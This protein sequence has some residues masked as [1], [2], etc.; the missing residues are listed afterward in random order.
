VLVPLDTRPLRDREVDALSVALIE[1]AIWFAEQIGGEVHVL[2]AWLPYGDGPMRQA[3]VPA[4]EI[5]EYH[6]VAGKE[7]LDELEKVIA[8]FRDR[9]ARTGVHVKIG[10]PRK[11]ISAF[12]VEN[13]V[14]LIVIGTVARSGIR[15]RILGNTAEV[16][17]GKLP[18]SMLV[19]R[20]EENRSGRDNRYASVREK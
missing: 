8:P 14:S 16:L 6:A 17:L 9:I 12:A 15:G 3:G 13:R 18:C 11:I 5:R 20:P 2:H 19:V 4:A 7:V 1:S 10:D